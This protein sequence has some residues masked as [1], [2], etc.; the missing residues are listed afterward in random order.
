MAKPPVAAFP[1]AALLDTVGAPPDEELVVVGEL[2][3]VRVVER[4]TLEVGLELVLEITLV[5]VVFELGVTVAT[6]EVE[7]L[8][9]EGPC[10]S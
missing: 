8:L 10:P 3:F 2:V 6:L 4:V 9:Y 1:T 5:T 7:V